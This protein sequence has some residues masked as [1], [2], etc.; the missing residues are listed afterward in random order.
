MPGGFKRS[1]PRYYKEKMFANRL[2]EIEI[3][4]TER[5]VYLAEI[6]RLSKFHD[7]PHAYYNERKRAAHD[8]VQHKSNLKDLF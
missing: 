3:E 5:E 4:T 8:K 6:Q 1:L 2:I 7:D